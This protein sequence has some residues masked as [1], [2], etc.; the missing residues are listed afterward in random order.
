M[1]SLDVV[2]VS[3]LCRRGIKK[4]F[5]RGVEVELKV[6]DL[7]FPAGV[8]VGFGMLRS[9]VVFGRSEVSV[10]EAWSFICSSEGGVNVE[11]LCGCPPRRQQRDLCS[12]FGC[13]QSL[14][15]VLGHWRELCGGERRWEGYWQW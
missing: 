9:L 15:R 7:L 10:V 3:V 14:Q 6:D 8:I 1:E 5:L 2:G 4:T 12:L 11:L 13:T